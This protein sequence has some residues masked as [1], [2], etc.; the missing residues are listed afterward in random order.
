MANYGDERHSY[1][2]REEEK[3]DTSGG[4]VEPASGQTPFG[5]FWQIRWLLIGG[6]KAKR[7]G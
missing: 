1:K 3:L 5:A 6:S 7:S 4:Y 2:R